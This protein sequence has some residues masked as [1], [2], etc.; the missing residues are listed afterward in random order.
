MV[1]LLAVVGFVIFLSIH[2][3]A[4]FLGPEP[5]DRL[6]TPESPQVSNL[7]IANYVLA[8]SL[9][10]SA[11]TNKEA[12]QAQ[13]D[14]LVT[15]NKQV[16]AISA[17]INSFE[18]TSDQAKFLINQQYQSDAANRPFALSLVAV[19]VLTLL[20]YGVQVIRR[21]FFD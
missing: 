11:N 14:E 18:T 20:Y 1:R 2:R 13:T 8:A 12:T 6:P 7:V 4:P 5:K 17:K 9:I 21:Y 15:L 3:G 16:A 19:L 10:F